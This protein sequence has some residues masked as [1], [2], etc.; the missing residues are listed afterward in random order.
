MAETRTPP[1]D[2]ALGRQTNIDGTS[3]RELRSR[4]SAA[5]VS[6]GDV[7]TIMVDN[8]FEEAPAKV[9]RAALRQKSLSAP[10]AR[11]AV[12]DKSSEASGS[13]S[14]QSYSGSEASYSESEE[15]EETEDEN[16]RDISLKD[17]ALHRL[18]GAAALK[19]TKPDGLTPVRMP[20]CGTAKQLIERAKMDLQ[21]RGIAGGTIALRY[22]V[23]SGR[24]L[25]V[26][27][28]REVK[29][30]VD[31]WCCEVAVAEIGGSEAM[32]LLA[33]I[34][35][36]KG[37]G[38]QWQSTA[39]TEEK[40][41]DGVAAWLF[42][43]PSSTLQV[44]LAELGSRGAIRSG[45]SLDY[46]LFLNGKK[47]LGSFGFVVCAAERRTEKIV[48]VK[49]LTKQVSNTVIFNEVDMLLRAQGHP[50]IVRYYGLWAEKKG[51]DQD[52]V[53]GTYQW[54]MV[55]DYFSKGDLYDRVAEG[56]R[57]LEQDC[58]P[59][60]HNILSALVHLHKLGIFHR[61]VK[62]ENMLMDTP[63][64]IVLTDFGISCLASKAEELAKTVGT[65]GYASPEMLA[66]KA[67]GFEGDDFGAGIVLYFMLSKSTPF[68]APTPALSAQRTHAG[69]VNLDYACFDH[70]SLDCRKLVLGFVCKDIETR[71]KAGNVLKTDYMRLCR[72]VATEPN[73]D[74]LSRTMGTR[75]PR[76]REGG[77]N[78]A[79]PHPTFLA[80]PTMGNLPLL[81]R[82]G[83]DQKQL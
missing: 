61:D 12:Q 81:K 1:A 19:T 37:Q 63:K 14:S 67:T 23:I 32:N 57:M 33:I 2:N 52:K 82:R 16:E 60:V 47:G 38:A 10:K 4:L 49:V 42:V 62:P 75:V 20:G 56:R 74:S 76:L 29:I 44:A 26:Y 17:V 34:P 46:T 71:L 64:R 39:S 24:S 5:T 21:L 15:E 65:V 18:H 27:S 28:E 66:G 55:L 6:M 77:G 79:S 54:S 83:L 8:F 69:K 22:C 80:P 13:D 31:L 36:A 11:T 43:C 72:G 9:S 73:L 35:E 48:A 30:K 3:L 51:S 41:K 68:Q 59:I 45:L 53:E 40:Q 7:T 78:D 70:I 58:I 25:I 50:N